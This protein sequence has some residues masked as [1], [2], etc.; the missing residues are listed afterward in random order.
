MTIVLLDI[1]G[2]FL[3]KSE[4]NNGL[5]FV[6]FQ[7]VIFLISYLLGY[8]L[9]KLN[10]KKRKHGNLV[11]SLKISISQFKLNCALVVFA[12]FL[13]SF[14]STHVNSNLGRADNVSPTISIVNYVCIILLPFLIGLKL[15]TLDGYKKFQR[16]SLLYF[17][18][19]L[20]SLAT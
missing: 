1:D 14:V 5:G 15:L 4:I 16:L 7:V 2:Y 13:F 18:I 9:I 3:S 19:L 10:F 20:L 8:L 11:S 12:P 17:A 6:Y